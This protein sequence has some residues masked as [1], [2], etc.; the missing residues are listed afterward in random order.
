MSVQHK[1][2]PWQG[3]TCVREDGCPGVA[4]LAEMKQLNVSHP[5]LWQEPVRSRLMMLRFMY[6]MSLE[7][8]MSLHTFLMG[9]LF[10]DASAA[11]PVY[12]PW[13]H[14]YFK[15]GVA[16]MLAFGYDQGHRL[17]L[18]NHTLECQPLTE[19]HLLGE[20]QQYL[21]LWLPVHKPTPGMVQQY[22]NAMIEACADPERWLEEGQVP[23]YRRLLAAVPTT[24]HT[25]LFQL[26]W[27]L[28]VVPLPVDRQEKL[29]LALM[30][31][32]TPDEAQTLR[33]LPRR[34]WSGA[35]YPDF[36]WLEAAFPQLVP[37][38]QNV[39]E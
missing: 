39:Q 13:N 29:A 25:R 14:L 12:Q 37:S 35:P 33:Q 27:V 4:S 22:W 11:V 38:S 32:Q 23:L 7:H 31:G 18:D 2:D 8:Q 9:V 21:E 19:S 24:Q 36:V 16:L 6:R 30:A 3:G 5:P 17:V 20:C 1:K 10:L 15:A 26:L 28:P 34:A